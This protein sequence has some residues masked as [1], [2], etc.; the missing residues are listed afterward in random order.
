MNRQHWPE[1]CVALV[2]VWVFLTPW[3]LPYFFPNS[4]ATGIVMWNHHV[5]GFAIAVAG[6]AAVAAYQI[7]EEWADIVLGVWLALS[8]LVLGF[9]SLTALTWNAMIMGA[10]VVILSAAALYTDPSAMRAA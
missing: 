5:V 10:V 1:W 4:V 8:P 9:A 6:L 3:V 7:W 2:G